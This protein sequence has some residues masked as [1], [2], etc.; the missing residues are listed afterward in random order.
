MKRGETHVI[1]PEV[2]RMAADL[3]ARATQL[4]DLVKGGQWRGDK[5]GLRATER[6]IRAGYQATK[7]RWSVSEL[8]R[9]VVTW[10]ALAGARL[11]VGDRSIGDG[12][13]DALTDYALAAIRK[14]C[15]ADA[16][17]KRKLTAVKRAT[18]RRAVLTFAP[19][20]PRR[21]GAPR[22]SERNADDRDA[23]VHAVLREL[24]IAGA[25]TKD[26]VRKHIERHVP[27]AREENRGPLRAAV[28]AS[29]R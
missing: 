21:S 19:A 6:W 12:S 24:G 25:T 23:A 17:P 14:S 13:V 18:V 15:A 7:P 22:R 27:I 1:A 9:Q 16:A 11:A 3:A 26:A 28:A 8:Q 5:A 4:H 10:I 29:R 20:R 2:I